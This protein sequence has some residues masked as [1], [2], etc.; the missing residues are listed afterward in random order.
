MSLYDLFTDKSSHPRCCNTIRLSGSDLQPEDKSTTHCWRRE[1]FSQGLNKNC[2]KADWG[3]T[4]PKN[5]GLGIAISAGQERDMPTWGACV[6]H[7][8]VDPETGAVKVHKLTGLLD[9][10]TVVHPDGALS[11]TEGSMLWGMNLALFEGTAFE[12]GQ[13]K[14]INLNTYTP[15]RMN[16][17]PILDINFVQNTE[18]PTGL[19]E[20]GLI[21]V[22]P[23]IANAIFNAVGARVRD[24]PIRP[25]AILA[26]MPS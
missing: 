24:L 17:L 26:A 19:G 3:C 23:A 18:F 8:E 16:N 10:G 25:E 2:E 6:A 1:T 11:Q 5:Q 14:D 20:P 15:L 12:K 4:L 7:V 13:V 21:A 9:C 22:A